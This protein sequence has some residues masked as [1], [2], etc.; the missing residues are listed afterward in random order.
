MVTEL[1][2]TRVVL[3]GL[4]IQVIVTVLNLIN[5]VIDVFV[6]NA[7]LGVVLALMYLGFKKG[8]EGWSWA[9][10][11]L[12]GSMLLLGFILGSISIPGIVLLLAGAMAR[13]GLA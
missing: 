13:Q 9:A 7:A 10:I 12:G 6:Y 4:I 1:R 3:V 8:K 11:L 2:G 5:G